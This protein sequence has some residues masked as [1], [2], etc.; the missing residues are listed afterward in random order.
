MIDLLV[1]GGG[2]T[3]LLMAAEAARHGMKCRVIDKSTGVPKESRA[4][5]IQPRTLEVFSFLGIVE[6]FLAKGLAVH[7]ANQM[8]GTEKLARISFEGLDSPY[9]F[10][11]SL[12]QSQTEEILRE[13]L[14]S[15]GVKLESE[16]EFLHLRQEENSVI[17]TV[18]HLD[19]GKE[20]EISSA[21]VVG[22][23]GA[24]S[25]VR[26][27]LGLSFL[28]KEIP[29]AFSLADLEIEW[30]LPHDEVFAFLGA[31]RPLITIPM[32]GLHKYRLVFIREKEQPTDP[33]L[34]EI[35]H[36]LKLA[37]ERD[38]RAS[39]LTWATN[40]FIHTRLVKDYRKG[41]VFLAGD[42]AHIHSP[43][44]GQGMNSGLQDA[45]NLAWKLASGDPLLIDTYSLERHSWAKKLLHA[46][47]RITQL[48]SLK[49]PL[50]RA[51]RN[52]LLKLAM[53]HMSHEVIR[54]LSQISFR[55][56]QS[57]IAMEKGFFHGGPKAG[58]RA[59]DVPLYSGR[60]KSNF[61][62]HLQ[63]GPRPTLFLFDAGEEVSL[64]KFPGAIRIHRKAGEGLSDPDGSAHERYG[65]Q[66]PSLYLIRP[67]LY[68]GLRS[69]PPDPAFQKLI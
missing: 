47:H 40:F 34:P 16:V 9:P 38:F 48:V 18:R 1:V 52:T 37:S 35:E 33:T 60:I 59:P 46:T 24:H 62:S 8:D 66:K 42:A 17:S 58:E 25:Q 20:E 13:H 15:F 65:A 53:P 10:I 61:Y 14:T 6:K 51:S 57:A 29:N 2:P 69:T 68:V 30:D 4:L 28:G 22:C 63:K 3:G 31:K 39:Q 7:A 49:N 45:F 21:W 64:E 11:L 26:N 44:G 56:P 43:A 19:T 23:D 55:Y 54:A 41:R 12:S 5:A 32:P 27:A 50:L 36:L 67:D